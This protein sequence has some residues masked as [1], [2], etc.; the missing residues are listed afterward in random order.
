MQATD[1][2]ITQQIDD[3]VALLQNVLGENLLGMYIYGSFLMG[4]LQKFSDIDL[5]VV[6][7]RETTREEKEQLGKALLKIS[8]VYAVSKDLKPVELTIVVKSQVNPWQYPPKFDFLYGDWMRKDFAAGNVEPWPT[9]ELPNLALV[10][11]QLLLSN[12]VLFG[13]KPETLLDAVPYKDFI[14]ATTREIDSLLEDIDWDTRNVLLT[15][16]RIWSTVETNTIRS[17]AD[18]ASWTIERL[19]DEYKPVL[20]KARH[21]L[22]GE[23]EDDWKEGEK[24]I[25]PCAEYIVQQIKKRIAVIDFSDSTHNSIVLH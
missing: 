9:K 14:L 6:S 4:G 16:A 24:L 23:R 5:F 12:K 17:K 19:L 22:L 20:V 7:K 10:V 21:I 13:P 1:K 25:R 15:L 2:I 11:T 3:C 18:A 8:G